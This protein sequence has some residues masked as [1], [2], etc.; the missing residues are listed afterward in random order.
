[1]LLGRFGERKNPYV[2][3]HSFGPDDTL[4][5]RDKDRERLVNR[6]ATDRIVVLVSTSGAG[7][8]S[9]IE[10]ALIKE[11]RAKE[12]FQVLPLVRGNPGAFIEGNQ[13]GTNPLVLG[14][15]ACFEGRDDRDVAQRVRELAGVRLDEYLDQRNFLRDNPSPKL[16]LFDQFEEIFTKDA[17][18]Q[19][20]LKDFFRQLGSALE[21]PRRFALLSMREEYLASLRPHVEFVPTGLSSVY[22]LELLDSTQAEEAIRKPAQ[23]EGVE[24]AEVAADALVRN[25][26][27][28]VDI[29][30]G[31]ERFVKEGDYV[32]PIQLQVVCHRIWTKLSRGQQVID[33][34]DVG[35]AEQIDSALEDYFNERVGKVAA[36]G[37]V[38][39]R[40]LREWFDDQLISPQRI[41][42]P[43]L[44]SAAREAGIGERALSALVDGFLIRRESR[45]GV[46]W[47]E[48]AHDRLIEPVKAANVDWFG[49]NLNILQ[50]SAL[51]WAKEGY[52]D[53]RLLRGELLKEAR[54][55]AEESPESLTEKEERLL[56]ESERHRDRVL[57][58]VQHRRRVRFLTR[59]SVL[60]L[61]LLSISLFVVAVLVGLRWSESEERASAA[62]EDIELAVSFYRRQV[63][64]RVEEREGLESGREAAVRFFRR[65]VE[66][67]LEERNRARLAASARTHSFR[68]GADY[69]ND[70]LSAILARHAYQFSSSPEQ[71]VTGEHAA[72]DYALR[73][74]L[75]ARPFARSIGWLFDGS[76][77]RNVAFGPQGE[78]VAYG[79]RGGGVELSVLPNRPSGSTKVSVTGEA[80]GIG[81]SRDTKQVAVATA[82]GV[83]VFS[84]PEGGF[85]SVA[86]VIE[87]RLFS[88]GGTATRNP[89]FSADGSQLAAF[90]LDG[91][92][93]AWQVSGARQSPL[94]MPKGSAEGVWTAI[95]VSKV[96]G[97]V[98]LGTA[99]GEVVVWN[100]D[101]ERGRRGQLSQPS[102]I[103][104]VDSLG[105]LSRTRRIVMVGFLTND[106]VL[107]MSASGRLFHW[108]AP[109]YGTSHEIPMRLSRS[110]AQSVEVDV[111]DSA[112]G[113]DIVSA[114]DAN[115]GHLVVGHPDGRVE[116][117]ELLHGHQE[118]TTEHT[119]GPR[120][121]L[122]ARHLA[123]VRLQSPPVHVAVS[124]N[125]RGLQAVA[126]GTK[127]EV[128]LWDLDGS[129][130]VGHMVVRGSGARALPGRQ[131]VQSLTF[132]SDGTEVVSVSS[133]GKVDNFRL[134]EFEPVDLYAVTE[135]GD[136]PGAL[137]SVRLL[138]NAAAGRSFNFA[139]LRPADQA[140]AARS[141]ELALR[142]LSSE[143]PI[144]AV[145]MHPGRQLLALGYATGGVLIQDT[146][147][148]GV[149]R[150]HE[151]SPIAG[152]SEVNALSFDASGDWVAIGDSGG[153]VQALRWDSESD[154]R[155]IRDASGGGVTALAFGPSLTL[156]S[157]DDD[158]NL[159][160]WEVNDTQFIE[161]IVLSAHQAPITALA[162]DPTGR[163]IVSADKSGRLIA[164]EAR[165][166]AVAEQVCEVV[167]RNLTRR[168]WRRYFGEADYVPACPNLP[169][170]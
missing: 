5:G 99:A 119:D 19:Q 63:D 141:A 20:S 11:M 129:A 7:K 6:L 128:R 166:D 3:P 142:H 76:A 44:G 47:Y 24:F 14:T 31:G 59:V 40:K 52:T 136:G 123:T 139:L 57:T 159:R 95:D 80:N 100:I 105:P 78:L 79:S 122:G 71:I 30:P 55:L 2:G 143:A 48:L 23:A 132:S 165:T 127:G 4:Y 104:I 145:A 29:G 64:Q 43:S 92:V 113:G 12:G 45:L 15:L 87:G 125:R 111:P 161:P 133:H 164:W 162:M 17:A 116:I 108:M 61:S 16:L 158:G 163:A 26:R 169:S 103:G 65:Q 10:A 25:L 94:V 149:G 120:S 146:G 134:K 86:G 101:W 154:D 109:D 77:P 18:G 21:D 42:Q 90:G 93:M 67:R 38:P 62:V 88:G 112:I 135:N 107:A 144:T 53:A 8:T 72:N 35:G 22:R 126:T 117:L 155:W 36:T 160:K 69:H 41:R 91:S 70:E 124:Q 152:G 170:D 66:Q 56:A 13:N 138:A 156:L 115:R 28:Q 68:A 9:L 74:S 89:V 60:A 168:E 102:R 130:Y 118:F 97:V 148:T 140:G 49:K 147:D 75:G 114:L 83:M 85:Q 151:I 73:W 50:H 58:D 131:Y 32:D 37:N 27:G 106:D 54:E 121:S 110:G 137:A 33:E 1:M 82:A 153:S 84:A 98:A 39:E 46:E 51:Q 96:G 150:S 81:F 157:G 34:E 167:W